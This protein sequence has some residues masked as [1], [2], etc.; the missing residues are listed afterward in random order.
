M[1]LSTAAFASVPEF[2]K[3]GSVQK[4]PSCPGLGFMTDPGSALAFGV[5]VWSLSREDRR[6]TV[7]AC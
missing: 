5:P 2:G 7:Q 3:R 4:E 6:D 1:V